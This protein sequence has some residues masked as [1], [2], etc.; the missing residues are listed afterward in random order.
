MQR[1][2]EKRPRIGITWTGERP[3]PDGRY[4]QSV[5][6]AGGEPVP[7]SSDADSW[8][9][10]LG[11]IQGLLLTGG[12][13]IEPSEY[14]ESNEQGLSKGINGRRDRLEREAFQL[15]RDR[16]LPILAICRGFQVV[17]VVMGG[18]LLQDIERQVPGSLTHPADLEQRDMPSRY[19]PVLVLP[20]TMLA[21]AVGFDGE[22]TVNSRHHQGLT[23][24]KVAAGLRA[25]AF[26]PDGIV[27][28]LEAKDGSFLMAVQC[29]PER[30]DE[31]PAEMAGLFSALVTEAARRL[32]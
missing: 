10:E 32:G 18:S 31:V 23:E 26:A 16:G 2:P 29:H 17:N 9:F 8:S 25:S 5:V 4:S 1:G 30:A 20:G 21:S 12:G 24:G 13:D 3:E 6:K 22:R 28:G 15:C 19:H 27:E 7:L 11:T 14:G